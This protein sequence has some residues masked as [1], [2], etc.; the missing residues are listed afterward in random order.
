M[1][2]KIK[3][4]FNMQK[5]ILF[6]NWVE[7][8]QKKIGGG[9]NT[10]QR[11][12]IEQFYKN[13]SFKLYFLS[14]GSSYTLFSGKTFL[15]E[16]ILKGFEYCKVYE[17]VNSPIYAPAGC[18][19]FG[20][21]VYFEDNT[22]LS[23]LNKIITEEKIDIIH[24]NNF[25]GLSLNVFK[26]KKY[27]PNLKIIFSL[28]NYYLFCPQVQ[29]WQ[30]G[31]HNCLGN[32]DGKSCAVCHRPAPAKLMKYMKL[33]YS[34]DIFLNNH[35]FTVLL[36]KLSL[37]KRKMTRPSVCEANVEKIERYR[38][39]LSKTVEYANDNVDL[40]LAVS[41]RVRNIAIKHGINSSKVITNYIGTK[42]AENSRDSLNSDINDKFFKIIYLG[43]M[44]SDKGFY[45]LLDAMEKWQNDQTKTIEVTFVARNVDS[46]AVHRIKKLKSKFHKVSFID[47]FNAQTFK[48]ITQGIHLGIVPSLWEDNLPQVAIELVSNG[49]PVLTSNLGGASELCNIDEFVF[50]AGDS[51]DMCNKIIAIKED[52]N[53]LNKFML[54][55]MHLVTMDEH[56]KKLSEI[57]DN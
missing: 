18:N 14:S 38:K 55:K 7:F 6:Y 19:G 8:A 28:H 37:L 35:F 51:E 39:F 45:F 21:D 49:I 46:E 30:N 33:L 1:V 34:I 52:R 42:A 5:K 17:I 43:Y 53:L 20:T 2:L 15:R 24:F 29:F 31:S 13:D 48:T 11:N 4:D 27:H 56:I 12:L 32:E 16:R 54:N 41:E 36:D 3:G 25:E 40:F 26:I 23:L 9:V 50:K 44:S 57:Y 47:G 10:Y 22:L